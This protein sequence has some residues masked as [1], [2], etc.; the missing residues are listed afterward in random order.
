MQHDITW[1][2]AIGQINGGAGNYIINL[3]GNFSLPNE[4]TPNNPRITSNSKVSIRGNY[5]ITLDAATNGNLLHIEND[6]TVILRGPTLQG[7]GAND[8]SLVYA[9]GA[10][11]LRDGAITGNNA[12]SGGGVDVSGTGAF[13]M[14]GGTISGNTS[15]DIGGGIYVAAGGTFAMSGG[16]ISGNNTAHGGGVYFEGVTFNMTGGTISGNDAHGAYGNSDN[17]GGGVD[18]AAGTFNMYKGTISG[19][20]TVNGGGVAIHSATFN[21]YGGTISGN[22]AYNGNGNHG[23]G[24]S[25]NGNGGSVFTKTGNS[26][27]TGTDGPDP[28]TAASNGAAVCDWSGSKYRNITAGP[29]VNVYTATDTD[30]NCS[31]FWQH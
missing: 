24:V 25:M 6:K 18:V 21:M 14:S 31:G 26:T 8:A 15:Y 1:A 2:A 29:G 19:N 9:V 4:N 12:D 17:N 27:I 22:S 10:F 13:T 11:Y 5:T 20:S 16:T 28:N 7:H 23:G 30:A 3:T